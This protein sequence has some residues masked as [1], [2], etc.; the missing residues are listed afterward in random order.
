MLTRMRVRIH[1]IPNLWYQNVDRSLQKRAN[2]CI[3]T[4]KV[5]N[6]TIQ[7]LM[8][9]EMPMCMRIWLSFTFTLKWENVPNCSQKCVND[10]I[11]T[12]L[13][14]MLGAQGLWAGRD[15]YCATPAVTRDLSFSGPIRRTAPFSRLL[16]HTRECGG[17][18]LTRIITGALIWRHHHYRL[19]CFVYSRLSNFS[20][21]RRLSQ[22]PVKGLQNWSLCSALKAV[23]R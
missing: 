4:A 2:E 3:F 6:M 19:V 22:L 8:S 21:I 9:K 16:R 12:V 11:F 15:L 13:V 23:S 5:D 1:I 17:S 18:I 7:R 20:A 10:L 14:D